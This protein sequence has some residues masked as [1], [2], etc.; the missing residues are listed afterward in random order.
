[1]ASKQYL[2]DLEQEYRTDLR[3]SKFTLEDAAASQPS[4]MGKWGTRYAKA[5]A[6]VASLEHR[7]AVLKASKKLKL[8]EMHSSTLKKKFNVDGTLT[9]QL[10]NAIVENDPEHIELFKKYLGEKELEGI[11][12]AAEKAA[13]QRSTMIRTLTDQYIAQYWSLQ[14]DKGTKVK[15]K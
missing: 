8:R 12:K 2:K 15:K 4:K 7:L 13:S 5:A 3:I 11:Y 1:M 6:R 9:E 10:L 14:T